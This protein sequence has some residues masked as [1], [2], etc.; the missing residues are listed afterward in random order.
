MKSFHDISI[1]HKLTLALLATSGIP[2]VIAFGLLIGFEF[3]NVRTRVLR[4]LVA[5]GEMLAVSTAATLQ[6]NDPRT[7]RET[8]APLK[9]RPEIVA[10]GLYKPDGRVFASYLRDPAQRFEFPAPQP[11]GHR[12]RDGF[13]E[14]FR[15]IGPEREPDGHL[16][17]RWDMGISNARLPQYIGLAVIVLFGLVLVA[18]WIS[19]RCQTLISKPILDLAANA[20][21]VRRE[22]NFALRVSKRGEDEIGQLTDAINQMLVD[23]GERDTALNRANHA[24]T[25]EVAVRRHAEDALRTLNDTLEQRVAERTAAAE[26]ANRAK[27]EF[28]ASMSHELRTPLNSI[29]G[30]TNLLL[31]N[32]AGTLGAEEITFLERVVTNGKH[33]LALINQILDLSKIEARK[34]DLELAPVD[35][36]SLIREAIALQESQ[37]RD[38]PVR[39]QIELPPGLAPL[40]TDGGKLRQVLANLVGN[41]IK[42]TERGTITLRVVTDPA[43]GVPLR[44]EV[45]DTG[46]GIPANRHTAIFAAFQQADSGTARRYGGT[47]LG[48]TISQALC[49]LMGYRITLTSAV[50]HGSTFTIHFASPESVPLPLPAAA[51]PNPN[52]NSRLVLV[53]DDEADSRTLLTHL[54]G[55]CGCRVVTASSGAEGLARARQLQP[56]FILLD[57]MMPE[58]NGWQVLNRLKLDPLLAGIPVAISSVV[59]RENRGT[60]LGVLDVLQKPVTR[61][62][63]VRLLDGQ[64]RPKVLLV[65]DSELDRQMA[66][67]NLGEFGAEF[68][69]A[70]NGREALDL[71]THFTP[72]L[73]LL[74]LLMPVMDGLTFL[75]LIRHDTRYQNLAV[76]V[77]TAKTLT[78]EELEQLHRQAQHILHKE[79]NLSASLQSLLHSSCHT[80]APPSAGANSIRNP[81]P[82][83]NPGPTPTAV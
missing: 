71:L 24:L 25:S 10:A 49:E 4:D 19:T 29:I 75:D 27:S 53:I 7:A 2:L 8:L 35:L 52:P 32:R 5:Q 1:R 12:S 72:D 34:M 70:T 40:P 3:R 79:N 57:L 9:S 20:Q 33:L 76:C 31:K 55:E 46:I 63:L 74:D 44:L 42:F 17:L 51:P 60:I 45:A 61:D 16:Y 73:I 56:D 11:P 59:A 78:P 68:R 43:T 65:E 15:R 30:F 22:K 80:P 14:L 48:L 37:L 67:R 38:R 82:L 47:G 18:L 21:A 81:S 26:A 41:A 58:M 28:L 64:S 77:V 54:I 69:C 39:L 62:D 83:A 6:F 50:G 66:A 13:V 23:I 36:D